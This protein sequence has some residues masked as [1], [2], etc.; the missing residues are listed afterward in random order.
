MISHPLTPSPDLWQ[1]LRQQLASAAKHSP[2]LA[3]ALARA[4]NVSERMDLEAAAKAATVIE[5]LDQIVEG[6]CRVSPR[7]AKP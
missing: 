2:W 4:S 7:P 1:A 3:R 5:V 6:T